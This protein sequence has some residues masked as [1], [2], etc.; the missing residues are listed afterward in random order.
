M[1]DGNNGTGIRIEQRSEWLNEQ[2]LEHWVYILG[3]N[4]FVAFFGR[5]WSVL[6]FL[7]ILSVVRPVK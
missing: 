6:C 3:L 2:D 1:G 5:T 4:G 7:C